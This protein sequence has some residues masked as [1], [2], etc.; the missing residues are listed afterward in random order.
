VGV[1]EIDRQHKEL[2]H[3]INN[4]VTA[5]KQHRC[6]DEIDGTLKFF[7]EY[8]VTHFAYEEKYMKDVHYPK[9]AQ[10]KTHHAQYVKHLS[11]LKNEA[12]VSRVKGSSYDLSMT[13]HQIVVD[14]II[15]HIMKVDKKFGKFLGARP[16]TR[17]V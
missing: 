15:D 9:Y 10:H 16:R 14:W 17:T 4:L 1:D 8:A 5:I 7:E 11:E 6:K 3:R 2:F 13:T 12:A